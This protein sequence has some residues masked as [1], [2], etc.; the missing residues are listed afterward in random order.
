MTERKRW[1]NTGLPVFWQGFEAGASPIQA[2]PLKPPF[3]IT[4]CCSVKLQLGRPR[5]EQHTEQPTKLECE[6]GYHTSTISLHIKLK[7]VKPYSVFPVT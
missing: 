1:K 5:Q 6:W 4:M 7:K 2:L 3:S